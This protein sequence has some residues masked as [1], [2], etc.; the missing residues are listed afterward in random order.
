[1][2]RVAAAR[3]AVVEEA[4]AQ[5]V[6]RLAPEG[7]RKEIRMLEEKEEAKARAVR[8]AAVEDTAVLLEMVDQVVVVPVGDHHHVMVLL[9]LLILVLVAVE[10]DILPMDLVEQVVQALLLLDI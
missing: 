2:G 10:E 8:A 4:V 1:M 7:G 9:Q 6:L 5:A 3:A